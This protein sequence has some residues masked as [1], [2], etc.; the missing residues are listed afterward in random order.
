MSY[1]SRRID[2]ELLAWKASQN[3]KP[4]LLRGGA[5]SGK[6][7][8]I[9]ELGR[10]IEFFLEV[11]FDEKQTIHELFKRDLSPRQ[12]CDELSAIFSTPVVPRRTLLFFD[13]IQACPAVARGVCIRSGA[14]RPK[15]HLLARLASRRARANQGSRGPL[16]NG[17][18][19]ASCH[20]RSV[21]ERMNI[22][23]CN[24]LSY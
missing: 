17:R 20:F 2:K 19:A 23:I 11:N 6:S 13:E 22:F 4:L 10:H 14:N 12:I 16:G 24:E 21:R 15:I 9:R 5:P 7:S 8:S 3:R 1:I 18:V